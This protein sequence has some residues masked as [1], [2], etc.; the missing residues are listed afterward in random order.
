MGA[1]GYTKLDRYRSHRANLDI[2]HCHS[3]DLVVIRLDAIP[4]EG[5]EI[6]VLAGKV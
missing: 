5:L 2:A 3:S 6:A 4:H 1:V